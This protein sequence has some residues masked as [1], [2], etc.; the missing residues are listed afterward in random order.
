MECL[1]GGDLMRNSV[2]I[3]SGLLATALLVSACAE[4]GY[5]GNSAGSHA[6][7]G[8]YDQN[9]RGGNGYRGNHGYGERHGNHYRGDGSRTLDPWLAETR[10]G[11]QFLRDH[12]NVSRRGEISERDARGA[13]EFFRRWADTDRN[14]RLTDPEVRT[15]LVHVRN[16]YGYRR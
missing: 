1:S 2:K 11:Q 7:D 9:Y 5:H 13:N 3:L 16:R 6:R 15:A 8:Y 10:E 4:K 12:Y 14:L